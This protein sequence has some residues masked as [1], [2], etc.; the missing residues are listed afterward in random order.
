MKDELLKEDSW[1]L[2]NKTAV[3]NIAII[4][5]FALSLMKLYFSL[6]P[7]S[8]LH[9]TKRKFKKYAKEC[10]LQIITVMT[11]DEISEEIKKNLRKVR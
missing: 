9:R 10:T 11:N 1:H 3:A 7:E 4:N 5:N 2:T 6:F 8:S